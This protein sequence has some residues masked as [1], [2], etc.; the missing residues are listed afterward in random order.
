PIA[1]AT[2]N[3]PQEPQQPQEPGAEA[4]PGSLLWGI[5]ASFRDYV[6]GPI[7]HGSISVTGGA[8]VEGGRY[9]FPQASSSVDPETRLGS[10]AY[11]GSVRFTGHG[12]QLSVVVGDP[13]ITITDAGRASL[14]AVGAG[15][16]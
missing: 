16:R 6:T 13:V 14:T 11:R 8:G 10:V 15:G 4:T 7:A 1:F 2:P 9:W 5:K 12:G 3:A